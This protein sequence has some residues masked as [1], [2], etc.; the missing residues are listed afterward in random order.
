MAKKTSKVTNTEKV[1]G[2]K[3]AV[4]VSGNDKNC[5]FNGQINV[6]DSTL[7]GTVVKKDVHGSATIEW[8]R[9]RFVSKY[10]RYSFRKSRIRVHNPS[11]MNAQIGQK[12][13]VARTRPIS[14]TKHHVI[15]KILDE[16]NTTEAK[17]K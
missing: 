14:K 7:V 3:A 5:P 6:K 9:A 1:L 11:S 4:K 16:V 2:A 8:E 17:Q 15:I 13:L 12:V 10:E